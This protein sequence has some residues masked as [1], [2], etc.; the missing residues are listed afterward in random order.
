MWLRFKT[1]FG[2]NKSLIALL[3]LAAGLIFYG[4]SYRTF[5]GDEMAVLDY[6]K[7]SPREFLVNYWNKPDNHP[8]LYYFLVVLV[9]KILPWNEF[10]V[11]F[12]SALSGLAIVYLVYIF[13][14]RVS[15]EKKVALLTGLFTA[16]SSYFILISQMARYHSLAALFSLLTFY[17]FY[18]LFIEGYSRRA[19]YLFLISLVA[20]GYTD[21]PHCFYVVVIVNIFYLYSLI[22][23]KANVPFFKWVGG[24]LAA[25]ALLSPLA[26]MIYHRIAVQ[27]D[28]GW[29]KINLLANSWVHIVMAIFFHIYSFLFGENIFPWNYFFF[30]AGVAVLLGVLFGFVYGFRKKLWTSGQIFVVVLG[31]ATVLANTFFMNMANP[32]YNF[33]VYPK[34]GF[35]AFPLWIM[36]FVL[37]LGKLPNKI[38]TTLFLL[39]AV[40][41]VFGLYNF[42]QA[43]NYLN[44]SYFRTFESFEYVRDHAKEGEYF[45]ISPHAGPGFYEFYREKYF[46]KLTPADWQKIP[47]LEKQ[48]KLWYFSAG[49]EGAET[50]FDPAMVVPEGY[51][52]LEQFDSVALDPI[53]KKVKEKVLGRPGYTY[54]YSIFLLEKI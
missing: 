23:R 27:G 40:V 36:I 2:L 26:W 47:T 37:C 31:V 9:G 41:A 49:S 10:M 43:K 22:R 42:Y 11:R 21:Y 1:W 53:F 13:S 29:D 5:W 33:I 25:A 39:W 35:V 8:P 4:I 30:G 52:I 15:G 54:K 51:K 44:P 19:W 17:F 3:A 46:N 7:E 6:L 32:R 18:Q 28:G 20:T 12:V 48:T 16:I 24:Q 45:A 34:F 38:R 14:F 50:T